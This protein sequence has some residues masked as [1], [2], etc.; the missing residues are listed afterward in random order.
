MTEGS[1]CGAKGL[2][3]RGTLVVGP[4]YVGFYCLEDSCLFPGFGLCFREV[5][6]LDS[7]R[8][9]NRVVQMSNFP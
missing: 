5:L 3:V 7:R 8:W 9:H 6:F 2:P 4:C 1:V